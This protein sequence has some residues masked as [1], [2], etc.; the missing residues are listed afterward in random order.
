MTDDNWQEV[1][2][3]T[4]RS[5]RRYSKLTLYQ[6]QPKK[7]ADCALQ[8]ILAEED[9]ARRCFSSAGVI[10]MALSSRTVQEGS[11]C[12]NTTILRK[13]LLESIKRCIKDVETAN[14]VHTQQSSARELMRNG[15][16]RQCRHRCLK[17][18]KFLKHIMVTQSNGS[19]WYHI[20]H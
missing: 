12:F 13:E 9:L 1:K 6:L 19:C 17:L 16:Q 2:R 4:H 7:I 3:K 8:S 18:M 20:L 15:L 14:K 10:G 11:T 5:R